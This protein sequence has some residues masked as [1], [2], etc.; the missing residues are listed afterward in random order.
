VWKPAIYLYPEEDTEVKVT[1][2]INGIFT[3]TIPSYNSG[4]DVFVTKEGKIF[5]RDMKNSYD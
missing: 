2:D 5:T 1:L 4:W 3:K